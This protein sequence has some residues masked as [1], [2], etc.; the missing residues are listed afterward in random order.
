MSY[1]GIKNIISIIVI[2]IAFS[3]NTESTTKIAKKI[4][5]KIVGIEQYNS[6][7]Q[8]AND[9]INIWVKNRLSGYSKQ[10]INDWQLDSLICFNQAANKCIICILTKTTFFTNSSADGLDY[11]YGIKMKNKWYFC[12]GSF[13]VLPRE[14]YQE[15]TNTPLSFEKLHEIAMKQ[16]YSGYLK[17]KGFLGLGGYEINDDFF[18]EI[19]DRDAY[20]YPF[21]TQKSWEESW[22]KLMR[23]NWSKRDTTVYKPDQ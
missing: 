7:Y 12:R 8:N 14:M 15:N 16:V 13:I 20:N 11:F 21:T 18:R 3:C 1:Q 23:E 17:P 5:T 9:S 6:I 2:F 4:S 22:L 19:Q 10:Y